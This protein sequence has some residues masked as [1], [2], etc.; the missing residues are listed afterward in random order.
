I[1]FDIHIVIKFLP[2]KFTVS[3]YNGQRTLAKAAFSITHQHN[4]STLIL[5]PSLCYQPNY[6]HP[7]HITSDISRSK[8][9]NFTL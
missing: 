4:Y 9:L 2:S 5:V 8:K 1:D 6:V 7:S 3:S